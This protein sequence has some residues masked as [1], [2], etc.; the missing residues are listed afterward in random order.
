VLLP[1]LEA[2]SDRLVHRSHHRQHRSLGRI[3]NR[4]VG[5]LGRASHRGLDQ[6]RVDEPPR[7]GRQD[8]GCAA[9]D[10]AQD[11]AGVSPRPHQRRPRH[12]V[13]DL[14][15]CGVGVAV[16]LQPLE[17]LEDVAHR[18]HHV[19]AGVAVGDRKDVEVVDLLLARLE[20][21]QRDGNHPAEAMEGWISHPGGLSPPWL[22]R[23]DPAYAALVTLFDFRQRV[24][25]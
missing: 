11:D 17:L 14:G 1:V 5:V 13:H 4:A 15:P 6:L 9:H 16:L 18:Q 10:L 7:R 2:R 25:T 3:A 12:R 8:L 23:G 19:V 24:Q 21:T 22:S 20:V